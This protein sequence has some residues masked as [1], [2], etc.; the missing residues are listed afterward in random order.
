MQGLQ[1]NQGMDS[2]AK[3]FPYVQ[4]QVSGRAHAHN[5]EQTPVMAA[6]DQGGQIVLGAVP[7]EAGVSP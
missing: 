2:V 1:Q 5:H 4:E 3:M 6:S 7:A